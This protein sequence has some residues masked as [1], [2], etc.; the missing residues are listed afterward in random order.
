LD[1]PSL[2]SLF[3]ALGVTLALA[4]LLG[5]LARRLGRP[6]VLG[7]LVAGILL[8]PTVVGRIWPA[9]EAWMFP[10]SG[11]ATEARLAVEALGAALFLLVAGLRVDLWTVARVGTRAAALAAAGMLLA[12]L[13]GFV[14]GLLVPHR[15][16]W[17]GEGS[18]L[19]FALFVATAL[20]ISAL[21]AVARTLADR[22]LSGTD[23]GMVVLASSAMQDVFGWTLFGALLAIAGGQTLP[24]VAT[25]L[26]ATGAVAVGIVVVGGRLL[27]WLFA[28]SESAMAAPG[29]ALAVLLPVALLAGA[30]AR[31]AGTDAFIGTFLVGVTVGSSRQARERTRGAV[32]Q[33][34]AGLFGPLLFAGVGL[35]LDLA[36]RFDVLLV[37]TL[38]GLATIGKLGG[39]YF[40]SRL[41]GFAP[42]E[43]LA[44][45]M[46]F[47]G[48][49]GAEVVLGS[50]ALH[51]GLADERMFTALVASALATMA[52]S[53]PLAAS[54]LRHG[55][56]IRFADHL[57]APAFVPRLDSRDAEGAIRELARTLSGVAGLPAAAVC[58]AVLERERCS[59]T[60]IPGEIALPHASFQGLTGPLV[61][62]GLVAEGIDF[63]AP[64]GLPARMVVL[65]LT[66]PADPTG[67]T[68]LLSAIARALH[69]P[70]V[71]EA[72][73][74]FR[75]LEEF[76]ELAALVRS[77]ESD[78]RPAGSRGRR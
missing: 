69:Q 72:L 3:A 14:P 62:V 42:R 51:A 68:R 58:E 46:A 25:S 43:S 2:T 67:Q 61:A 27:D 37:L 20:L 76:G 34:F 47:N 55:A 1:E 45:G 18:S 49:G 28:R 74:R 41:A 60:G 33:L 54:I 63:G 71:R 40:G 73:S 53:S 6:V 5:G 64:D 65:V 31:I 26:L 77:A 9:L 8:G 21:P 56:P 7:E 12:F 10:A 15:V 36:A 22:E 32:D 44:V 24:G 70:E 50:A 4:R 13:A 59:A 57:V 48:R 30:L 35:S 19:L 23:L 39:G 29:G 52:I 17:S 11:P 66:P 38:I 78:G 16:G 75:E